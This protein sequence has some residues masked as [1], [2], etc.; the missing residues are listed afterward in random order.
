MTADQIESEVVR[1]IAFI[2]R[3]YS[4]LGLPYSIELSTRPEEKYIGSLEIWEKSEA[5]L[6]AA[7]KAAGKDFKINPGDGA[8]YGPKLDFHVK[9]S[10]G[11]VWQCG[12]IQLDM[13]L[14]ERF[15][16]T[17]V[18]KNGQ[19]VRPVML[20]R[21]IF[22]S[23]ER[24]IGIL[25]E[26]FAGAFPMW[27]AP[28]QLR[29]IPVKNEFHLDY[30]KEVVDMLAKKGFRVELDDRDEKLGYRI[31][32]AQMKKIP[33]QLVLGNQERDEKTV[34]Y[35]EYGH[36][37]QTTLPVDDFIAMIEEEVRTKALHHMDEQ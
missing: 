27:L 5:A 33:Y 31:R 35:R 1:L 32:E 2:D 34:T 15:D 29:V 13:N 21:V 26:H 37:K 9:D 11:R 18:D 16:L 19:K 17:Y 12:T 10:L 20:H 3:V 6:A 25:I 28:V 30:A 22:G 36:Q 23:I 24:F 7:C 14:P 4:S 8:F